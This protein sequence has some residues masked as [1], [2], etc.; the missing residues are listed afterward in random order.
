MKNYNAMVQRLDQA[1]HEYAH[2]K[3]EIESRIGDRLRAQQKI[4]LSVVQKC[5]G[6]TVGLHNRRDFHSGSATWAIALREGFRVESLHP[7]HVVISSLVTP[8]VQQAPVTYRLS[9]DWLTWSDRQVASMLR[10]EIRALKE[11]ER[12]YRTYDTQY[13]LKALAKE[14]SRQEK[15]LEKLKQTGAKLEASLAP[16]AVR[17]NSE[18]VSA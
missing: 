9:L 15:A 16:K 17:G 5:N 4:A 1:H 3:A 7:T 8:T 12:A 2:A 14:I 11:Q 18:R 13:E 6:L 10:A